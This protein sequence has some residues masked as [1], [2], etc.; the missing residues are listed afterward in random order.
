MLDKNYTIEKG[1]LAEVPTRFRMGATAM[2]GVESLVN[3][4]SWQ[5][6]GLV[7]RYFKDKVPEGDDIFLVQSRIVLSKITYFNPQTLDK[8]HLKVVF[9][10]AA[11]MLGFPNADPEKM[12]DLTRHTYPVFSNWMAAANKFMRQPKSSVNNVVKDQPDMKVDWCR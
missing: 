7:D 4:L 6:P 10:L 8:V 1:F 9:S 5:Q 3:I 2:L 12:A 11:K